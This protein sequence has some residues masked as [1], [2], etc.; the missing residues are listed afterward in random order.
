M[1]GGR[2]DG[3]G[4]LDVLADNFVGVCETHSVIVRR[5]RVS[6]FIRLELLHGPFIVSSWSDRI[7]SIN[8]LHDAEHRDC[9]VIN[10]DDGVEEYGVKQSFKRGRT[11]T[12]SETIACYVIVFLA[13]LSLVLII[14]WGF[15]LT[16]TSALLV[17]YPA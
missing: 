13:L 4:K 14:V 9:F 8:R 6:F 17:N 7:I 3:A 15:S 5:N 16:D 2:K 10:S 11:M 12:M 1:S